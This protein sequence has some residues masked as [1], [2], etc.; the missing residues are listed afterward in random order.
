MQARD[1]MVSPVIT[2]GENEAVRDAARLLIE[3][4]ISAVPVVDDAG[5]LVGIVSEAD[6]MRRPEAG[7][8]RPSSWW[9]SLLMGERTIATEYVKSRAVKVKDVMTR[10]VKTAS[11]ETQLHE[12]ADL[13][14]E[15]H[16]KRV[17][18]LSESGDLVGIIS[19]ANIIQAV[20]S[21]RPEAETSLPDAQIR[22]KL[23]DELKRHPWSRVH[24]LNV[25]VTNGTVDLWGFVQSEVERRAITIAAEA[26]PGVIAISD[27]LTCEQPGSISP[28]H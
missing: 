23:L 21:A 5:K 14:E 25:T 8:E 3:N 4:R 7:T 10:E 22:A 11:P 6:L 18:I 20:A 28:R 19:R 16:I 26:I 9:L 12:I 15:N 1:V 27:H 13:L 2:V 17:P 24:K